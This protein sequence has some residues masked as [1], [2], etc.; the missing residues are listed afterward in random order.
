MPSSCF[1]FADVSFKTFCKS[2]LACSL[3]C[4]C[5][6]TIALSSLMFWKRSNFS[7]SAASAFYN[8]AFSSSSV[9]ALLTS[10][11][12]RK[13][14]YTSCCSVWP[15]FSRLIEVIAVSWVSERYGGSFLLTI[16]LMGDCSVR[17]F[18]G[19]P[20]MGSHSIWSEL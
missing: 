7:D 17:S 1:V 19:L 11:A 20:D 2:T 16:C 4:R 8:C 13:K 9:F 15:S 14:S 10:I 3:D 12:V 18:M 6:S 5:S